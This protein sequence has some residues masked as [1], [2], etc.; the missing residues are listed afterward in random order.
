M[1]ISGTK[2]IWILE[3]KPRVREPSILCFSYQQEQ[4]VVVPKS[5]SPQ[6]AGFKVF[7]AFNHSLL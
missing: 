3:K 5:A 2:T 7:L 1:A 6:K 4:E